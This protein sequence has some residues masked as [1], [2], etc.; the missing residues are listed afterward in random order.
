MS[1]MW[2][3]WRRRSPSS[4]RVSSGSKLR[5]SRLL[6]NIRGP[7]GGGGEG[8]RDCTGTVPGDRETPLGCQAL[9]HGIPGAGEIGARVASASERQHA[10][11]AEPLGEG[12][13]LARRTSVGA[14]RQAQ[15]R[16]GISLDAVRTALQDEKFRLEALQV[17]DDLWP[18]VREHRVIGARRQRQIELRAL[19]RPRP[20]SSDAPVPG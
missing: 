1:S 9:H 14:R 6:E 12:Y 3:S 13:E 8:A 2:S 15:M 20:V 10:T 16:Q 18:E 19:G 17:R 5:I 4:A 7:A 11:V